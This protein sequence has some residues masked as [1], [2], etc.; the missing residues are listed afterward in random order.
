MRPE[1]ICLTLLVAAGARAAL[2]GH[3]DGR[4]GIAGEPEPASRVH[5]EVVLVRHAEKQ[6]SSCDCALSKEGVKR[7]KQLRRLLDEDPVIGI[8]RSNCRRTAETARPL[9]KACREA[10][11]R[12]REDCGVEVAY[13]RKGAPRPLEE[14]ADDIVAELSELF[15]SMRPG[16]VVVVSHGELIP[17]FLDRF[18][19]ET[20]GAVR[21]DDL[22]RLQVRLGTRISCAGVSRSKYGAPAAD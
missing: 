11:H 21:Y 22:F 10:A 17:V 15:R 9:R 4:A 12:P 6:C 5:R 8:V 2:P 16:T 13:V 20:T 19:G 1:L 3:A 7:S 18:C 14:G